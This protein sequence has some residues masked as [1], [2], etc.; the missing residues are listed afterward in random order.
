LHE[1]VVELN[2]VIA[3]AVASRYRG[4][5][6]PLDDLEQV[7]ALGLVKA[8]QGFDQGFDKGF[9]TYAVPTMRGEVRH[10]FAPTRGW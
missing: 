9:L 5:G 8:V 10:Y 2:L 1:Q 4:R 3:R 7:A 6:V